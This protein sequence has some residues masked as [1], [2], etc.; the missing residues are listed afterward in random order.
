MPI[1]LTDYLQSHPEVSVMWH[2]DQRVWIFAVDDPAG[3]ATEVAE[4]DLGAP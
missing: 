4:A 1:R 2:A 3:E